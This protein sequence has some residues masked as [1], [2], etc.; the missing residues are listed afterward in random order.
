[1]DAK[2]FSLG[3]SRIGLKFGLLVRKLDGPSKKLN[4]ILRSQFVTLKA[5]GTDNP[6]SQDVIL[7]RGQH[8]KYAPYAFTEQGVARIS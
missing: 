2:I 1:M 5:A 6:R 8:L 7:S 3:Y 4:S